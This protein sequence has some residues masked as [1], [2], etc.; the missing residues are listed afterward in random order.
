MLLITLLS[1]SDQE[2]YN[3][4][5]P[6]KHSSARGDIDG[7]TLPEVTVYAS[8]YQEQMTFTVTGDYGNNNYGGYYSGSQ[9]TYWGS[10]DGGGN[11]SSGFYSS[12]YQDPY[13]G[14]KAKWDRL[15]DDE[16]NLAL[17]DPVSANL[18]RLNSETALSSTIQRWGNNTT[19][20]NS[21]S[22]GNGDAYRHALFNALNVRSVGPI[23]TER[24][25]NAHENFSGNPALER[26]MDL[27]NNRV[28]RE[29]SAANPDVPLSALEALIFRA[30]IDGDLSK[31]SGPS[32]VPTNQAG[33]SSGDIPE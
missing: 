26:A 25:G 18:I 6:D 17:G 7:G 32:L 20:R 31:I 12:A 21:M 16:K 2:S 5:T 33:N 8:H 1:C 11:V 13:A 4:V 10:Y 22:N 27:N 9:G 15:S 29:I 24:F 19:G 14:F 23:I 3:S 28:G 30:T